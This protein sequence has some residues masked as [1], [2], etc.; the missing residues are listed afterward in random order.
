MSYDLRFY[1]RLDAR[2]LAPDEVKDFCAAR[3]WF[4]KETPI[5]DGHDFQI[6]YDNAET[7]TNFSLEYHDPKVQT[8]DDETVVPEGFVDTGL[9]FNINYGRPPS[10]GREAMPVVKDLMDALDVFVADPQ[11]HEIGGTDQPKQCGAWEL[12]QTW[13][14]GNMILARTEYVSRA[15]I[16]RGRTYM[17]ARDRIQ[18]A[19]GDGYYVPSLFFMRRKGRRRFRALDAK[20][21]VVSTWT[22][23]IPALFP[24]CDNVILL[25][26]K[27][28]ES[29]TEPPMFRNCVVSYRS[30]MR[31]LRPFLETYDDAACPHAM[32]VP[33]RHAAVASGI[34]Q[35][36][37]FSDDTM[38]LEPL[39]YTI[40]TPNTWYVRR[41]IGAAIIIF[42]IGVFMHGIG[43]AAITQAREAW[44]ANDAVGVV[45]SAKRALWVTALPSD[46]ASAYFWLGVG[47]YRQGKLADA[48]AHER[49]AI[50]L[51][52]EYAAPYVTLG[53]ILK[54]QG[55]RDAAWEFAQRA[56]ALDPE[57]A[58]AQ[59]LIGVLLLEGGRAADAVPYFAKA[60]Q[61]D[62]SQNAFAQN[63]QNAIRGAS[64][65]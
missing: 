65:R 56:V 54:D 27:G 60:M 43:V 14:A 49:K 50:A 29:S 33:M 28:V 35:S 57:Y 16:T 46:R 7:G 58:W 32:V 4:Q 10:H 55:K 9:S 47:E 63:Y 59:N 18:E 3:S 6:C 38:A 44:R 61:L 52:Q 19:L 64:T 25:Q 1:K 2:Q 5:G 26:R 42:L 22:D 21:R 17:D 15:T 51:R 53:A 23:G 24:R 37:P 36:F 20:V 39:D 48:E 31:R 62:A 13:D 30:L 8:A 41:A 11:D 34:F 40:P 45:R 12:I